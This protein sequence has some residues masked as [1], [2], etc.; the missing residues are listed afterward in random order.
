MKTI[1]KQ[2]APTPMLKTIILD[3]DG[4]MF[5]SRNANIQFY[6]HLRTHFGFP[7]MDEEEIDYV[8]AHTVYS[9]IS[10]IFRNYPEQNI[11]DI[12]QY[13]EQITY[14]PFLK[15]MKIEPDL[16]PFLQ[17]NQTHYNLAIATNRTDTMVPLLHEFDL[18]KYFGKVM[19]A[20]NS[21]KPKPAADPLLE[22]TEHFNCSIE[23]SIY[24]GD[25]H[26]DEEAALN[27]GMRLIAFRNRKIRAE[28]YVDSF[29]EILE[30]PPFT[31]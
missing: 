14:R 27:C 16:V 25:T 21:R 4:V 12:Y 8:H 29:S 15:Y 2:V 5:D 30:L 6:N 20:D 22:I 31:R 13:K 18:Y 28:F 26:I 17:K 11:D 7:E 1:D 23:E 9:S 3:C 10:H 19:T 24:V